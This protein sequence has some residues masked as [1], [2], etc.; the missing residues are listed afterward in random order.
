MA[1][2]VI[3]GSTDEALEASLYVDA[4]RF[5]SPATYDHIIIVTLTSIQNVESLI[6]D[7]L[8]PLTGKERNI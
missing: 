1:A 6:L 7:L 5:T 4:E 3:S 2:F 8:W